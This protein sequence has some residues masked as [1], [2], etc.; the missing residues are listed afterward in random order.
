MLGGTLN[1][2]PKYVVQCHYHTDAFEEHFFLSSS[3]LEKSYKKK[4]IC[5]NDDGCYSKKIYY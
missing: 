5:T 2:I 3:I 4:N 1:Q